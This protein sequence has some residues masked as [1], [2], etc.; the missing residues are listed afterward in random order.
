VTE[1]GSTREIGRTTDIVVPRPTLSR[2][3]WGHA[4]WVGLFALLAWAWAPAE[5]YRAGALFHDW[6]NMAEFGSAFLRPNFHDWD[7]YLADMVVTVQIAIWGTTLAECS[8]SRSRSSPPPTS[9]RNGWCSR[10]AA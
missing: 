2:R 8:A 5:M 6:R 9:V 4:L 10:C 3:L 1:I 7:T